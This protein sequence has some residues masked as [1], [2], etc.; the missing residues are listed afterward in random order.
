MLLASAAAIV[1]YA[2]RTH[3]FCTLQNPFNITSSITGQLKMFLKIIY[4][5]VTILTTKAKT[6]QDQKQRCACNEVYMTAFARSVVQDAACVAMSRFVA[7]LSDIQH[8]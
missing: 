1:V 7:Y 5:L 8:E 4:P 2:A 3:V 6:R